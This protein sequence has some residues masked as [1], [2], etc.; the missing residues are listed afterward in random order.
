MAL[1]KQKNSLCDSEGAVCLLSEGWRRHEDQSAFCTY[2]WTLRPPFVFICFTLAG[3][4]RATLREHSFGAHTQ[5]FVPPARLQRRFL[6]LCF[7]FPNQVRSAEM[8]RATDRDRPVHLYCRLLCSVVG[9][10]GRHE[11]V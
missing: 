1:V 3:G 2:R 11:M 6:L 10:G 7:N 4:W 5:K 8:V 9:G